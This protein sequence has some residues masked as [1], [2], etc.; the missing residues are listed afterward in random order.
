MKK[1][2]F[3]LD[4]IS[5]KFTQQAFTESSGTSINAY[6]ECCLVIKMGG[7]GTPKT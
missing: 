5:T 7:D 2:N 4:T 6:E 1:S 3:I